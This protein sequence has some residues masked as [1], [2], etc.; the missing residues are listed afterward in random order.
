[1]KIIDV[2]IGKIHP[3]ENNPRINENAVHYVA[4][5]IKAYGFK[6][7]IVIDKD[8]VIVAGHTRYKAAVGIGMKTVPCV[9]ADDLTPKQVKAFRIADN[10]VS[11]YSLWDNKLLLSELDGLD[12]MFTG[13]NLGG[14]SITP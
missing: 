5:S 10:K 7:P 11:D 9:V 14:C 12:D 8:N 6:V 4:D 2:P 1:M 3:Y 13:F